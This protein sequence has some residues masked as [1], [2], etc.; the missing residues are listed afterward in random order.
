[1]R[2]AVPGFGGIGG[3]EDLECDDTVGRISILDRLVFSLAK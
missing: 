3:A 1:M 2:R